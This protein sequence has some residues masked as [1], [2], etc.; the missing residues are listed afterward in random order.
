MFE[1]NCITAPETDFLKLNYNKEKDLFDLKWGYGK[2]IE[3]SNGREV[4]IEQDGSI[5]D[6]ATGTQIH[7]NHMQWFLLHNN[8]KA[9]EQICN[10]LKTSAKLA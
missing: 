7:T 6:I 9:I 2:I 10:E 4:G 1:Y 3:C 5:T 8:F